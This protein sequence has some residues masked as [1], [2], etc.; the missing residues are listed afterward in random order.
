[1]TDFLV[2]LRE[3]F[4]TFKDDELKHLKQNKSKKN[5]DS[6]LLQLL[7][8]S[9]FFMEQYIQQQFKTV[10]RFRKKTYYN[11]RGYPVKLNTKKEMKFNFKV[12]RRKN[13]KNEKK[14][15]ILKD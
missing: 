10:P 14:T 2:E 7:M 13:Y 9:K 5:Q 3:L 6:L 15:L 11:F 4:D 12:S 1:M 8:E